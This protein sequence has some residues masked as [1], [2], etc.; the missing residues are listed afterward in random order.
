MPTAQRSTRP[1]CVEF[2][3]L[4]SPLSWALLDARDLRQPA[5]HEQPTHDPLE[6]HA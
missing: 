6:L 3:P 1:V 2:T 5:Y 4:P